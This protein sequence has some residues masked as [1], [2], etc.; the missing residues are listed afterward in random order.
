MGKIADNIAEKTKVKHEIYLVHNGKDV[1]LVAEFE[2]GP[3]F[4]ILAG[5]ELLVKNT[6]YI[7]YRLDICGNKIKYY[8]K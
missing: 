1:E 5:A 2:S 6:K 4:W 8:A 7:I 3:Y